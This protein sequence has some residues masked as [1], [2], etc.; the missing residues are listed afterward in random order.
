[1]MEWI[2][3]CQQYTAQTTIPKANTGQQSLHTGSPSNNSVPNT[4]TNTS[5]ASQTM[6]IDPHRMSQTVAGTNHVTLTVV[7]LAG[8]H[9]DDTSATYLYHKSVHD[10]RSMQS[11]T[12]N[13][14]HDLIPA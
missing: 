8:K 9:F 1:M 12:G 6:Q 11:R 4:Q 3:V 2:S 7:K 5:L 10:Q 14:S 13:T